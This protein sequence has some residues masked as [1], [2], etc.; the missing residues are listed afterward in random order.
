MN[1]LKVILI[2]LFC[3]LLLSEECSEN[4]IL[5]SVTVAPNPA[6]DQVVFIIDLAQDSYLNITI[7]D[8]YGN[9]ASEPVKNVSYSTG[10]LHIEVQTNKLT[11][12]VYLAN[13]QADKEMKTVKFVIVR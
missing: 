3:S 8:S 10:E 1:A 5:H 11:A 12:G 7:Y 13:I 2:L 6:S 9:I 4:K